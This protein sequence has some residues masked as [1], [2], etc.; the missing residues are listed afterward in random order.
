M[1]SAPRHAR[2]SL[3]NLALALGSLLFTLLAIELGVRAFVDFERSR[4]LAVYDLDHERAQARRE[5]PRLPRSRVD[6]H[7]HAHPAV[8]GSA[9]VE[10]RARP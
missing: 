2:T 8:E 6:P 3:A 1:S 5:P 7:V 9:I 10:R 4:P